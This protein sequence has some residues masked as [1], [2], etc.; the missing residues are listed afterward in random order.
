MAT[1][2][3]F[4]STALGLRVTHGSSF[5]EVWPSRDRELR[6]DVGPTGCAVKLSLTAD[7]APRPSTRRGLRTEEPRCPAAVQETQQAEPASAVPLVQ[8]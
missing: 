6:W 4:P 3:M 8:T 5:P 7:D 1:T 2:R